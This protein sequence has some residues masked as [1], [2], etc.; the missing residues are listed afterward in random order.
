MRKLARA[1]IEFIFNYPKDLQPS[2]TE[3][4]EKAAYD[5]REKLKKIDKHNQ[6]MDGPKISIQWELPWSTLDTEV[7]VQH[8][9]I[10][11]VERKFPFYALLGLHGEEGVRVVG[12][13]D[14][15]RDY[16]IIE[17]L[18]SET[19]AASRLSYMHKDSIFMLDF[20]GQTR[21]KAFQ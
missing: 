1:T 10:P 5:F 6:L 13:A 3:R 20:D 17:Q 15:D 19:N 12:E 21:V 4:L 9:P 8:R 18:T 11:A 16:A 7:P 14:H 2:E